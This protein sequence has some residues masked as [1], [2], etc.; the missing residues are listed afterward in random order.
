MPV[1]QAR[2]MASSTQERERLKQMT[3]RPKSERRLRIGGPYGALYYSGSGCDG[4]AGKHDAAQRTGAGSNGLVSGQRVVEGRNRPRPSGDR[5]GEDGA[6]RGPAPP[7][8]GP[9]LM[10]GG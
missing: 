6:R 9:P 8:T 4:I 10:R 1:V 7:G 2:P 5:G 3:W